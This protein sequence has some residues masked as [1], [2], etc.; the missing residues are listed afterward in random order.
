MSDPLKSVGTE[1]RY[2]PVCAGS[3]ERLEEFDINRNK[4]LEQSNR[5]NGGSTVSLSEG[6]ER[7]RSEEDGPG[8]DASFFGLEELPQR[9]G[10]LCKGEILIIVKCRFGVMVIAVEPFDHLQG[11]NVHG[12]LLV[13]A[14]HGEVLIEGVK[15]LR[16]V[17][18]RD[19]LY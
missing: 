16:S 6:Q 17:T 18:L 2:L 8:M 1:I 11:W 7:D 4:L 9:L 19:G 10:I 5:V 15:L 13:A 14:A 3:L 12:S